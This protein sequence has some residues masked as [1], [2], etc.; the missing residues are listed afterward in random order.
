MTHRR[1]KRKETHSQQVSLTRMVKGGFESLV[2][3]DELVVVDDSTLSPVRKTVAVS[4]LTKSKLKDRR[5]R[6][7]AMAM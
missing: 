5:S 3:V 6:T 2:T 1:N 7:L 4:S